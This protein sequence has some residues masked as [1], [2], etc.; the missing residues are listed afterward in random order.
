MNE[1]T[2]PRLMADLA[3]A[4]RSLS[5]MMSELNSLQ[6]DFL[7]IEKRAKELAAALSEQEERSKNE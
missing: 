5:N 1:T 7:A 3:M 2:I 6:L 4:N